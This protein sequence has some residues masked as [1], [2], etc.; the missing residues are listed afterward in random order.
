VKSFG[1]FMSKIA[2]EPVGYVEL[3]TANSGQHPEPF[4]NLG[5]LAAEL[6]VRALAVSLIG[7][8]V[9]ALFELL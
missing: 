3:P 6:V 1:G 5:S 7:A 4:K 9:V 8:S 2:T